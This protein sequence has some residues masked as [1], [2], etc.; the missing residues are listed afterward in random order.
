MGRGTD[1]FASSG[2]T[3]TAAGNA[4]LA[5]AFGG[6]QSATAEGANFLV[7]FASSVLSLH[8]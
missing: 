7:N 5:A 6:M 8:L 2:S 4:D 1:S 3:L